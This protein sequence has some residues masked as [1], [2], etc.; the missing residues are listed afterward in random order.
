MTRLIEQLRLDS[1]TKLKE[2]YAL[3]HFLSSELECPEKSTQSAAL[4]EELFEI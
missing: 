3:S 4:A 1:F 2:I